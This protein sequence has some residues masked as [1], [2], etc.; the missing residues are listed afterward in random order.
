MKRNRN[1][2]PL[3]RQHHNGLMA[4]LLLKKGIAKNASVKV[5]KEFLIQYLND[6]LKEHFEKEELVCRN[7]CTADDL[8]ITFETVCKQHRTIQNTIGELQDS[9]ESAS[10][11]NQLIEL[12]EKNIRFEE[13][14]FFPLIEQN[15]TVDELNKTGE[16]LQ[17]LS[18]NNCINFEVKFWE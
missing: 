9:N 16:E 11:L 1:L 8:K 13:R 12:L 17:Y 7:L 15:C 2:Q 18:S 4:V 5:M 14:I 3:S 6:E 10:V